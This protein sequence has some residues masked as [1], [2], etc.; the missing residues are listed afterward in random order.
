M[1]VDSRNKFDRPRHDVK[2]GGE[3]EDEAKEEG[4]RN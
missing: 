2:G 1:N 3:I 4:D